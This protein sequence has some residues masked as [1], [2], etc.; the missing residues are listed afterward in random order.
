MKEE[1]ILLNI[2]IL[3]INNYICNAISLLNEI[4]KSHISTLSSK[5]IR[6]GGIALVFGV[7][8]FIMKKI[9]NIPHLYIS[10]D[11]NIFSKKTNKYLKPSYD[12]GG[13]LQ[14]V[15]KINGSYKSFRVHRL[16]AL[17]FIEN[18]Q[19]KPC[20]NHINAIRDDNRIE[21]LEWCTHKEN[22]AHSYRL[23]NQ[24]CGVKNGAS[25]K[26]I[27]IETSVIYET[28]K[29]ACKHERYCMTYIS[30]MLN[31]K[32]NNKTKLMYYDNYGI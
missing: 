9:K 22:T 7:G 11:G 32:F 23:G 6:V 17:T 29:D 28:L 30:Q 18:P 27:N 2:L 4:K 19:N 25:K 16:L 15:L 31:G 1:Y 24:G 14:I 21:N 3:K 8:I 12:S 10:V 20:V 26:V 5:L 13:Y